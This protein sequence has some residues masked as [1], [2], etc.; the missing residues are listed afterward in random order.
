M[1]LEEEMERCKTDIEAQNKVISEAEMNIKQQKEE[2]EKELA[3]AA[4]KKPQ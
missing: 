4:A 3:T 1:E 2:G